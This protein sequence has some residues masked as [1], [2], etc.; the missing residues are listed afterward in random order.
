MPH[1]VVTVAEELLDGTTEERLVAGLTDA[2]LAV[3]GEWAR[4]LVVI[5][6][7]GV[8]TARFAVGGELGKAPAPAVHFSSRA[9][10]FTQVPDAAERLAAG[11]TDA[12]AAVFGEELRKDIGVTLIGTADDRSAVGGVLFANA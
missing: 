9:G 5:E 2:V 4:P 7:H 6:F 3:Y 8:P 12:L 10:L 1:C 11:F